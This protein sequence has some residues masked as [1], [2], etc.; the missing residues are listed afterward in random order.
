MRRDPEPGDTEGPRAHDV[1][2]VMHPEEDP[3]DPDQGDEG[4]DHRDED[5]A[6][7][8]AGSGQEDEKYRSVADDRAE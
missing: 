2:Q 4:G 6:P 1:G 7:P 5:G 3:A 8:A